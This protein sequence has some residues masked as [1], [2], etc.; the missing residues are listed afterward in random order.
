MGQA[1]HAAKIIEDLAPAS[2]AIT[3]ASLTQASKQQ[4]QI[5]GATDD[6]KKSSRWRRDGFLFEAIAWIAARQAGTPRTYLKD[7]HIKS[8]TQGIDG[9]MIEMDPAGP[10]VSRATIFEDKC[11]ENPRDIFRDDVMKAFGD[12]HKN[13]RGPDLVAGAA[14]LIKESGIDGTA[15]VTAAARVLDLAY[16][17]YRASLAVTAAHDSLKGRIA[18]FKGYD[19]LKD[20][21]AEQRVGTT[22][23][24]NGDL[25]D[26]FDNL[27]D[28]AIAALDSMEGA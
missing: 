11:S 16:R 20:I 2:P 18:L 24:V 8:T 1:L 21:K 12:H 26:W 27:A 9:L 28:H 14:A 10:E 13:L 4:L 7:P 23:I 17:R 6:H 5:S 3:A 22:F 19:K 15:A 25:R